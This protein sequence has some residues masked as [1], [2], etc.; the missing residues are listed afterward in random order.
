VVLIMVQPTVTLTAQ[1]TRRCE[2]RW[3][4]WACLMMQVEAL[5][6]PRH[7]SVHLL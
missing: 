5:P 7:P 2:S 6:A 3:D 4:G 1:S